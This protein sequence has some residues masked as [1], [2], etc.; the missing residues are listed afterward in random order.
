[1]RLPP[2]LGF[3]T[4]AGPCGA[5]A[6]P[7]ATPG[8]LGPQA[9][10][11]SPV[12]AGP[13]PLAATGGVSVDF[14]S[15]GYLDVSV[16]PVASRP[17]RVARPRALGSPIRAPPGRR[18]RAPRRGVSLLAAPF[19][20]FPCLGIRRAPIPPRAP[21]P[22]RAARQARGRTR[23][24]LFFHPT[25]CGSQGARGEPRGPEAARADGTCGPALP[26]P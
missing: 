11:P 1:M 14:L 26:S 20:G 4:A 22:G 2:G 3:L 8:G 5:R 17:R 9:T 18:P 23:S 16:P 10:T 12:W 19:V 13:R 15:S 25:L 24:R 6:R 21:R 7:T